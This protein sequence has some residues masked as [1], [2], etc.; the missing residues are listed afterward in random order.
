MKM[1]TKKLDAI[2]NP[3]SIAIIGASRDEKSVGHAILR[4]LTVGCVFKCKYCKP[5]EGG[6]YPINPNA[7]EILGV[8]CYAKLGDVSDEVDLAIIAVP[9]KIVPAIMKECA[10]KKVKG[11]IIIS[12]GFAELGKEVKK[13]QDEIAKIAKAAKIPLVGPNCLGI[14]RPAASMNA[15]FA[16]STPPQGNVAFISQS[17]ALAD[18]II[19][20]AIEERY[21]FSAVI[22]YGNGADL[23]VYDFLEWL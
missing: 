4:N 2:F 14:I 16:P 6:I 17:G 7:D 3:K 1:E 8:K 5:F 10:K 11:I 19:D 23:D 21:G 9:A 22:S 20:W 12:A 18:S 15:S 13:L